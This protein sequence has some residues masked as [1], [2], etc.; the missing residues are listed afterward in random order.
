M[1]TVAILALLVVV[2]GGLFAVQVSTRL[3]LV[4]QAGGTLDIS[5]VPAR[6]TRFLREVV[7]QTKVIAEKPAVGIAHA[8]VFWGFVAFAG[9]SGSQF[10]KG[11]HI[12]D[13]T[14]TTAFRLYAL[15]LVPFAVGVLG[16]I[17]L[18][19][20]R[21]VVVRPEALGPLSRTPG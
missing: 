5:N 18:L 4:R 9:Y 14:G 6:A 19:L 15:A 2:F 21:R 16:G 7:F 17:L 3:R 12:V 1:I 11:L 10:L 13:L 20:V 8:L